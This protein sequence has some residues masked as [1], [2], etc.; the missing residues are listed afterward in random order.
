MDHRNQGLQISESESKLRDLRRIGAPREHQ[1]EMQKTE[2]GSVVLFL[3][4]RECAEQ[5]QARGEG[6]HSTF[7]EEDRVAAWDVDVLVASE[8]ASEASLEKVTNELTLVREV[9]SLGPTLGEFLRNQRRVDRDGDIVR[10][11]AF[12]GGVVGHQEQNNH[13]V[14]ADAKIR[15]L[16]VVN[17]VV[18]LSRVR[19]ARVPPGEGSKCG[20]GFFGRANMGWAGPSERS[21]VRWA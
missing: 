17:K 1:E 19:C 13:G 14:A 2:G 16:D 7:L 8:G 5:P 3:N 12:K 9:N 10:R 18:G 11:P 4:V 20:P 21:T 15:A 6:L